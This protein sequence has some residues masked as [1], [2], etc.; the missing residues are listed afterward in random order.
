MNDLPPATFDELADEMLVRAA[1]LASP[2][3]LIEMLDA[4]DNEVRA[5]KRRLKILTTVGME[6]T[7]VTNKQI[8]EVLGVDRRTLFKR[9]DQ[10]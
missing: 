4:A 10:L 9:R 8:A 1:R 5:A 6:R 2:E 3:R 7:D